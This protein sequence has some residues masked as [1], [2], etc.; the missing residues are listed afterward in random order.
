MDLG[1]KPDI[2]PPFGADHLMRERPQVCRMVD[3]PRSKTKRRG[4]EL[5]SGGLGLHFKWVRGCYAAPRRWH[6][7]RVLKELRECPIHVGGVWKVSWAEGIA[8]AKALG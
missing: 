3:T 7:N 8:C 1:D 2:P 5:V 6:L 4:D